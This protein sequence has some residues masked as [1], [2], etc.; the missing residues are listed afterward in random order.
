MD[1]LPPPLAFVVLGLSAVAISAQVGPVADPLPN[2][3]KRGL[4][5]EIKDVVRLPET[6]G[7]RPADQDV[8]PAGWARVQ[9]VRDLP[10]GRRFAND[11]RGFLYLLEGHPMALSLEQKKAED[12]L[13]PGWPYFQHAEPH[14]I[15]EAG[16]YAVGGFMAVPQ[17]GAFNLSFGGT[18]TTGD[19]TL[20]TTSP[21][22]VCG[23]GEYY[24]CWWE[25]TDLGTVTFAQRGT[26]LM[27]FT[28]VGRFNDSS[29]SLTK[30]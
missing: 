16:T 25:R 7:V 29:F 15:D 24:H 30:K 5:V 21:V 20:T 8:S 11:S 17:G 13:I 19:V 9:F 6:R 23:G 12:P 2:I 28:Q 14:V 18:I 1:S 4:A 10:D 26:Y 22:T 27:T 3:V